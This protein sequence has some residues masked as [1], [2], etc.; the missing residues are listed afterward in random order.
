MKAERHRSHLRQ[1]FFFLIVGGASAVIDAG[2]FWLLVT[3]GM[4][5]TLASVISFCAAFAV[6]YRG[7]RDLVFR[8][9]ASRR[10]LVRY[11]VLVVINLGLSAGGVALGTEVL[12]FSP[13]VAKVA[14]MIL[15]ALINFF[16]M[17]LWVFRE[18]SEPNPVSTPLS[19]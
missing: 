16:V 11:T 17:R 14:T 5:P 7:N 18:R 3:L 1:G 2:V 4:W 12:N 19:E 13:I 6:N 8:A 15:V 9:Q 10:A